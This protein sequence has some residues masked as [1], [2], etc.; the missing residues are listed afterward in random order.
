MGKLLDL[1]PAKRISVGYWKG[2]PLAR[3][4]PFVEL[5]TEGVLLLYFSKG[6]V[7]TGTL[8]RSGATEGFDP[9]AFL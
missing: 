9:E 6:N 5:T 4:T 2:I 8:H 1:D 7:E 3:S